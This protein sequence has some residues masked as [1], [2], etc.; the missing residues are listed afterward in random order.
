MTSTLADSEMMTLAMAGRAVTPVTSYLAVEP[1]V[2][3]STEGFE[4]SGIGLRGVGQGG[5]IGH[6]TG[7][8]FGRVASQVFDFQAYLHNSLADAWKAC[9]GGARRLEIKVETTGREVV[10]VPT[11]VVTGGGGSAGVA[12]CMA[13]AAWALDLPTEFTQNRGDVWT[14]RL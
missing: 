7:A 1:G 10:D 11:S 14:V 8:G 2:R 3:P 13:E 4:P 5:S 9:G 12:A 6:G